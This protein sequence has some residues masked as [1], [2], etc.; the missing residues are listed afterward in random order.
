MKLHMNHS[1][2]L[3]LS[4]TFRKK[5]VLDNV[6]HLPL[7]IKIK[8]FSM[9]MK[10]HMKEWDQDSREKMESSLLLIKNVEYRPED[11]DTIDTKRR[12]RGY[13]F[14]NAPGDIAGFRTGYF[15]NQELE[16]RCF[17]NDYDFKSPWNQYKI[18]LPCHDM[19][20]STYKGGKIDE[21]KVEDF[22]IDT[23]KLSEDVHS[24]IGDREWDNHNNVFWAAK[25]CRCLQCDIIRLQYHKQNPQSRAFNGKI[26][27]IYCRTEYD[28]REKKWKTETKQ[29]VLAR[30]RKIT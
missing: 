19:N 8:I 7:D 15:Y 11:Y 18:L 21:D 27:K 16:I 10:T 29:Q 12:M 17:W 24:Q 4:E 28:P 5:Q 26:N 6:Y 14:R 9:S 2:K 23:G 20:L 13:E 30:K 1:Q 22:Y 25:K 3:K